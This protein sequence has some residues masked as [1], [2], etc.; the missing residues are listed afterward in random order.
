MLRIK[1]ISKQ[2]V[3]FWITDMLQNDTQSMQY[4]SKI[5]VFIFWRRRFYSKCQILQTFRMKCRVYF[6]LHSVNV[7]FIVNK[8]R[9]SL[10]HFLS[11]LPGSNFR[12]DDEETNFTRNIRRRLVTQ[13]LAAPYLQCRH[14]VPGLLTKFSFVILDIQLAAL[15][16]VSANSTPYKNLIYEYSRLVE[17]YVLQISKY[18]PTFT[19]NT[20]LFEMTVG[21]LKTSHTNYT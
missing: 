20:G 19:Q 13:S 11:K 10:L 4:Q 14:I 18:F 15:N 21:V 12:L 17:F 2:C 8:I 7:N 3:S 9:A 1:V 6:H 16:I 5:Y